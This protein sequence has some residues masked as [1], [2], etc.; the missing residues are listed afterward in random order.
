MATAVSTEQKIITRALEVLALI[1]GTGSYQ[2]TLGTGGDGQ[3]VADSRPNWDEAELPAVSVFQGDVEPED[4][5]NEAQKVLRKMTLMFR[6]SIKRG[7]SAS[8]ARIFLA[9]ILRAVRA[10]GDKWNVSGIDLAFRTEEGPHRIEI[11]EGTYE[12]TGV[13]QEIFIYYIGTHLDLEA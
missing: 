7:S 3:S 8:T 1:N 10:A 5:D 11:A 12:I 2:T 9:D 13:Q 6:G 4:I